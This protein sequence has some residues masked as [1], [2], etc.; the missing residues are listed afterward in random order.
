MWPSNVGGMNKSSG[1]PTVRNVNRDPERFPGEPLY[2]FALS[3]ERRCA[4]ASSWTHVIKLGAERR[5]TLELFH[6][7]ESLGLESHQKCSPSS[8]V[9]HHMLAAVVCQITPL[10]HCFSW[11][12]YGYPI[13]SFANLVMY[14]AGRSLPGLVHCLPSSSLSLVASCPVTSVCEGIAMQRRI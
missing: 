5:K 6:Y 2:T 7:G 3:P 11:P 13:T 10:L 12:L 14:Q 1:Q 4:Q 8:T 9:E